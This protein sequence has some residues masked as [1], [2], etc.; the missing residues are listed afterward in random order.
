MALA[1]QY[2]VA[3]INVLMKS[4]RLPFI[5][6]GR[7]IRLIVVLVGV[8]FASGVAVVRRLEVRVTFDAAGLEGGQPLG[9]DLRLLPGDQGRLLGH[10]RKAVGHCQALKFTFCIRTL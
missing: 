2:F 7:N 3:T 4:R 6:Q 8:S 1:N 5:F 10:L 9:L